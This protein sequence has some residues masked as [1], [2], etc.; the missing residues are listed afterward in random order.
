MDQDNLDFDP[1]SGFN[2]TTNTFHSLRP[3]IHLPP[4]DLP[5]S[6]AEYALSLQ[7]KSSRPDAT[8]LINA[9]SGQRVSYPE[10]LRQTKT[11]ASYLQ[12]VTKLSKN[13]VAFVLCPNSVKVP[14]LYF[15]LLSLGV[16]VSPGNPVSTDADISHQIGL[17]KPAIAFA[18]SA[19][20]HKLPRLKHKTIL[21]D[22]PEFNEMTTSGGAKTELVKV[23]VSQSDVAAIL[24]SS[25]TTGRVKGVMLTHRNLM[26]V[27][28]GSYWARQG[29]E[30]PTVEIFTIP[31]FHVYGFFYSFKAVALCESVVVMERFDVRKMLRAVDDFRV[32]D[33]AV[34]P[35]VVVAMTK[36]D[37]AEGYNL[38]SLESVA[39]GG[40]P[41]GKDVI[42]AFK[43]KFPRVCLWQGYGLTESSGAVSRS[44]NPDESLRWGSVGKVTASYE[45]KVVDPDTGNA[46]PPGKRG[47]LWV[48]GPAIMKGYVSDPK[49]TSATLDSNGWLRT[50]DLCY[51]DEDGFVFVVDRLKEL[52]KY[53]GYQV[54]PAELEQLLQSHPE[55]ADAAVIPY[56]DEEAGQVPMAFVVKQPQ[57]SI[58]EDD[59]I[60]FVAKQVAPYKKVRRV[61]FVQ[62][63]PKSPAGKILRK[64]LRKM[65]L[66]GLSSR[67]YLSSSNMDDDV[68]DPRSGFNSRTKTFHSLRPPIHL[69]PEDLP[70]SVAEYALSL[71]SNSPWPD[72]TALINSA[73]GHRTS[74]PEFLKQTKTLASYLQ[75]VTK[76]SKNEVAFVL[77]PNSVKVPV[78]YFALLSLGVVISPGNPVSTEADIS[79]QIG[80][81][82]PAIAF[83]TSST[84]HKLPRLKHKTILL[85]SPEFDEMTTTTKR[86]GGVV[87]PELAGRVG[88]SQS[89]V[90]AILYSSGTTGRVKGVML[91]HRNLIAIVSGYYSARQERESPAVALF[92]MPFFHSF[93][94]VYSLKSVALCETVVVMERF[95]V[96][97]MLRAVEEFR[98]THVLV[99]P[100]VVVA[101]L[102][103]DVTDGYDLKSLEG[104]G[105][106]G[107]PLGKDVIAAF[108][109]RFPAVVLWQSF[110]MDFA[111]VNLDLKSNFMGLNSLCFWFPIRYP[112]LCTVNSVL[113]AIP[114]MQGYGVTEATGP[115]S[116]SHGPEESNRWGSV[117]RLIASY[118]AK[119]VDPDTG[120]ALPPGKQGELWIRGPTIMKG[121]A[122][123]PKA[124]SAT[125]DSNG[126]LKTGDLCYID[127]DGFV[128]IVDRLKELIKYKGY[129]VAP[130]EL[131][132]LLQSHPDIADAAVIPYPDEDAGQV[133]MAFVVKQPQSSISERDI[134]DFVA[135][136]VAPYKKVRR[137]SFVQSIP[138]SPAG[139][140]LRKDLRKMILPGLSSRL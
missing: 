42:A 82:K 108:K 32:T 72:A 102:K 97:K 61:S 56:P 120:D 36:I 64:D 99:A 8:A 89:D 85:D 81:C 123:D 69:P 92:T 100:P 111:V 110:K 86:S 74:Y 60:N 19:T 44:E 35:P 112:E 109:A 67:L 116:R 18:T 22:S 26:A 52:I 34:A 121:Y 73:T 77:C 95:D 50:G 1:R 131:E 101:M 91:T 29:R 4:E 129:Q 136:Q 5:L 54:A 70:L 96:R 20:A 47:E 83:A 51:I 140:I 107:A 55:I 84:A 33:M 11:L 23:E 38:E 59:I 63:I 87:V 98:V 134:I 76:L 41:L 124:T 10:F 104:V 43:A 7:S 80:L 90:A 68:I 13:E 130:A 27:V 24:Y 79:H 119:I 118:E 21:L 135:K 78:L 57:S 62:S 115:V 88:V 16:V 117:G 103:V 139:K 66:P 105:S 46:L 25:G 12:N 2:S 106:G 93:G 132:Q 126:W 71:Q 114:Q 75:N 125:L 6:V 137:V 17:C 15:A 31:F 3:P 9:A 28:S 39:S 128:F 53:K 40:A 138:K 65:V 94:F 49:A 133:P 122:G 14:V 37:L 127:E 113:M 48:R 30:S 45:A 58:R